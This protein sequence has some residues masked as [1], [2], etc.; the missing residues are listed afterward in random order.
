MDVLLRVGAVM[1]SS[2]EQKLEAMHMKIHGCLQD[3][4]EIIVRHPDKEQI[5]QLKERF[6]DSVE[7]HFQFERSFLD[8]LPNSEKKGHLESHN[9]L[10]SKSH[11]F[12]QGEYLDIEKFM[13]LQYAF[14]RHDL[15]FDTE[16]E[17][18]AE[19]AV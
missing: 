8:K 18:I 19:K 11:S 17:S 13:D 12:F 16:I 6:L 2:A 4:S 10:W 9:D 1:P 14:A 15:E 7:K 3:I 5:D